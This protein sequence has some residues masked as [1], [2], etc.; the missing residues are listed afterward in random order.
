MDGLPTPLRNDLKFRLQGG[1]GD[2]GGDILALSQQG[3]HGKKEPGIVGKFTAALKKPFQRQGED[4][5]PSESSG[6][7]DFSALLG[8][9]PA[10]GGK[11]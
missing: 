1:M 11:H 5:G 3:G 2:G 7:P 8:G 4:H 6:T 10:S 9:A